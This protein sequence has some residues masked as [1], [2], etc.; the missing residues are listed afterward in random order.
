[1]NL[2]WDLIELVAQLEDK[3]VLGM[4]DEARRKWELSSACPPH[5]LKGPQGQLEM[6]L[7]A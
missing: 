1:M 2:C 3:K 7:T 6:T 5:E 4:V